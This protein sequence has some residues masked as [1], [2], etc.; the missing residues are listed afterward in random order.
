MMLKT[1]AR[2]VRQR[3]RDEP[4]LR[5]VAASADAFLVSYPK[6]GR[7]WLRY[8][9]SCY[10]AESAGLGFEP[11][12]TTTFGVLPNFDRDPVR[13]VDAFIGRGA[14]ADLPLVPVS[15]LPYRPQLFLDRP[16]LFLVRDPR[17]VIVSAYFH[18][19]RHKKSFSGDMD[20]FLSEQHYGLHA[21]IAYLNSWAEGLKSHPHHV[22]SYEEMLANPE[23]VVTG[24]LTFLGEEP[25]PD[26]LAR[27]VTAAQFDRMRDKERDSGIPGHDY[28]RTDSQS[29]RMRS[30]K[31]GTFG[32][33]LREDQA[34]LIVERCRRELSPE[35]RAL[36]AITHPDF[37]SFRE[38]R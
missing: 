30:G 28:D 36:I 12:L 8:L 15:H 27:A 16:V 22:I 7:T 31:A 11:D 14:K 33:W 35:A 20:A 5:M 9:L 3:W 17:D 18:A 1:L 23:Q 19:T 6:S 13:G 4:Y 10:F 24:I 29:M 34:N 25:R 37:Q 38:G 26:I 32:Q 21:L 2:T